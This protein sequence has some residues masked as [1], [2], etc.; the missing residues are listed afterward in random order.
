MWWHRVPHAAFFQFGEAQNQLTALD[1][2]GVNVLA[3]R[4]LVCISLCTKLYGRRLGSGRQACRMRCVRRITH[5]I[6]PRR[7]VG[8][9]AAEHD[10]FAAASDVEAIPLCE[11][12]FFAVDVNRSLSAEIDHTDLPTFREI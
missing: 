12:K 3:N 10:L 9:R 6:E 8:L 7:L 11:C 4:P 2:P 1:T 5:Q